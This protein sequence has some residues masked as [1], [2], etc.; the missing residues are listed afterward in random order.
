MSISYTPYDFVV[1]SD[2]RDEIVIRGVNTGGYVFFNLPLGALLLL[3][4]V[5]IFKADSVWEQILAAVGGLIAIAV[6]LPPMFTIYFFDSGKITVSGT[7]SI[8][9]FGSI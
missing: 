4:S 8:R 6:M 2:L 3:L 9:S 5:Y 7:L 1:Y